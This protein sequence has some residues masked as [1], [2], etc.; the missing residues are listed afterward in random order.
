[1]TKFPQSPDFIYPK[2]FDPNA[3]VGE[4]EDELLWR[5]HDLTHIFW[6][7]Y[8]RGTPLDLDFNT[9]VLLHFQIVQELDKRGFVHIHPINNLDIIQVAP[10]RMIKYAAN[11]KSADEEHTAQNVKKEAS[12]YFTTPIVVKKEEIEEKKETVD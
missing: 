10:A 7:K 11:L 5:Y 1:M 12:L 8:E 4:L 3:N 2:D 6:N 9:L